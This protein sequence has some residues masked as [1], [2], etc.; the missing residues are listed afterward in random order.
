LPSAKT[1]AGKDIQRH[2]MRHE[3]IEVLAQAQDCSLE[4]QEIM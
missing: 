3:N 1:G 2:E 4:L